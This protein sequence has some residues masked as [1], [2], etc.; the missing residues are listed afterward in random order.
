MPATSPD[1]ILGHVFEAR[2]FSSRIT[3]DLCAR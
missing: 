3:A 2:D 1:E